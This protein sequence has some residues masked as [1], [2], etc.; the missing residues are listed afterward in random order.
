MVYNLDKKS[1]QILYQLDIDSRQS[2]RQIAKKVRLSREVVQYRIKQMEEKGI[3]RGYQTLIDVS[4]LG[5]LCCRFLIKFQKDSAEEEAKI[6]EYY[7]NHPRFWWVDSVDGFRDLGIACWVKDIYELFEIKE[8]MIRRFGEFIYD[9][10]IA[11]YSK[12][13]IFR[14][15][16]L[17]EKRDGYGEIK[18]MF[19]PERADFDNKDIEILRLITSNARMTSVE[20]SGKTGISAPNVSYRIKK[21]IRQGII[22]DFRAILDLQKMGYYWYKIEMQLTDLNVKK[23]MIEFFRRHP[24]IVYAYET[25]SDN[26][27][28]VEMEVQSYEE[29]RNVL[30]EIRNLFG[31]SIKKYHHLLWYNEHK[32]VF[33]P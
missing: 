13:Y 11:F 5:Y 27:I 18:T 24:N 14:R 7:K 1:R 21:M 15:K 22:K 2:Y 10:N 26:D 12:F 3:I 28:E 6:I 33:M 16:Y 31:K 9:L 19:F 30:N 23:G 8:D 20:I 4:K 32:F 25:I 17:S 29:F